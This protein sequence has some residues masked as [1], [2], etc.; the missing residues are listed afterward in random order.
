ME[1][2]GQVTDPGRDRRGEPIEPGLECSRRTMFAVRSGPRRD[3]A[4]A[5]A[6]H[7]PAGRMPAEAVRC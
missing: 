7:L 2:V 5:R 3:G 1:P 6:P 4:A